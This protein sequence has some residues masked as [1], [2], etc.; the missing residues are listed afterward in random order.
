MIKS[1]T[2]PTAPKETP[3]NGTPGPAGK[4]VP[5]TTRAV[6]NTAQSSGSG[7]DGTTQSADW[8]AE[9]RVGG[10]TPAADEPKGPPMRSGSGGADREGHTEESHRGQY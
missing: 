7:S 9:A 8:L 4:S 3:P 10:G 5:D 1:D 2:I 6:G